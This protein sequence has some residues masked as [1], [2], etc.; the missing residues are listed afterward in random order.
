[1][2]LS[3]SRIDGV[4]GGYMICSAQMTIF[5]AARTARAPTR[6]KG[7]IYPHSARLSLRA[8]SPPEGSAPR[9]IASAPHLCSRC[10]Y[11][12]L[13]S[14]TG[15]APAGPPFGRPPPPCRMAMRRGSSLHGSLTFAP[16]AVNCF[17]RS[18][19][20]GQGEDGLADEVEQ[21]RRA[22][23]QQTE[24]EA[25]QKGGQSALDGHGQHIDVEL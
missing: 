5:I 21:L 24:I 8:A 15:T 17:L 11:A 14:A 2:V 6:A 23:E 18:Q 10:P 4:A 19:H 13:C 3:C 25:Q 7:S 12:S 22:G 9:D 16:P 1:M 20:I